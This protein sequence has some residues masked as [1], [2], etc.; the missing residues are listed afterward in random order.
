MKG[1]I[2][3]RSKGS[4][5]LRHEGPPD[6]TGKRKYL[7]ETIKG[8]KKEAERVL[9]E[10]LAAIENGGYVAKHKETV[11]DFMQRWLDTYAATNT[12]LR[13]QEGYQGNIQR[14]ITPAIGNV[15]LQKLTPSYIQ[16][17]YA[18]LLEKGLSNRTVLHVHRVLSEAL[19]HAARWGVLARNPADATTPPRA[20]QEELEMWDVPTVNL[21][22]EAVTG[23]RFQDFYHL[24]LLTGMR[25]SEL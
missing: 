11:S 7:S 13:T 10:R 22:L 5:Q 1:S 21:F 25:R 4:W 19:K 15:E 18:A 9:R 17:M 14:Y 2:R 12:T 6:G 16:G 8:N 24:A 20:E 3:Q 23:H